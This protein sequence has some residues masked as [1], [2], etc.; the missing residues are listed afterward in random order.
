MREVGSIVTSE[1]SKVPFDIAHLSEFGLSSLL[2]VLASSDITYALEGDVLR[3]DN[4]VLMKPV[5]L[6]T[7]IYVAARNGRCCGRSGVKRA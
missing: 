6:S 2:Q 1:S 7:N 5:V 3:V 4:S